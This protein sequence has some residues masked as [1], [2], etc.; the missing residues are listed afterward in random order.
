MTVNCFIQL[1][2]DNLL[3]L[4]LCLSMAHNFLCC[5]HN[6]YCISV[7]CMTI[8]F[9]LL[10]S[11]PFINCF[12]LLCPWPYSYWCSGVPDPTLIDAAV[13]MTLLFFTV[14]S[15]VHDP[16]HIIQWCPWLY[17]YLFSGV[18]DPAHIF[19]EQCPWPYSFLMQRCPTVHDPTLIYAA[20]SMTLD[21]LFNKRHYDHRIRPDHDGD[22]I[23]VVFSFKTDEHICTLEH[24]IVNIRRTWEV[25]IIKYKKFP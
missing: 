13:S 21:D 10:Q 23:Q 25:I 24:L 17:S 16:T 22:P 12:L 6:P 18:H 4:R 15:R 5:V 11:C 14:Y 9:L 2:P 19:M 20:V 7:V 3:F 8:I 1:C